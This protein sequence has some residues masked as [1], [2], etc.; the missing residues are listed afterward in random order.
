MVN[1]VFKPEALADNEFKRDDVFGSGLDL[2]RQ[3][4]DRDEMI[5]RLSS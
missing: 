2:G 3:G 4:V 5:L 1:L